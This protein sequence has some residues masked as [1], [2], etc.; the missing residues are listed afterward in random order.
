VV[1]PIAS[2]PLLQLS[3]VHAAGVNWLVQSS[4]NLMHGRHAVIENR[5]LQWLASSA[6]VHTAGRREFD[7]CDRTDVFHRG[8]PQEELSTRGD[9]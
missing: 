7:Y 1:L 9:I 6:G 8:L 4:V 3:L 5:A 2:R